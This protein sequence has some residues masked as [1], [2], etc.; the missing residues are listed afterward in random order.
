MALAANREVTQTG[1]FAAVSESMASCA[2]DVVDYR[3]SFSQKHSTDP[4]SVD[5]GTSAVD[6]DDGAKQTR[7]S[8]SI[9]HPTG[10]LA[11]HLALDVVTCESFSRF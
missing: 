1:L 4:S 10:S 11:K 8:R 5:S 2:I 3:R 6:T 9:L 7:T